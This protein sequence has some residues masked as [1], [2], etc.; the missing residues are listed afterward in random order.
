MS[1]AKI[2]YFYLDIMYH[3][4]YLCT[5]NVNINDMSAVKGVL[6]M[7]LIFAISVPCF[8][9]GVAIKRKKNKWLH[10]TE[11]TKTTDVNWDNQSKADSFVY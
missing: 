1:A 9:N 7:A 6:L 4:D 5:V 2:F 10:A 3:N 8:G 11:R